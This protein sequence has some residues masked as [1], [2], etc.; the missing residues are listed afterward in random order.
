MKSKMQKR[1]EE[2][3][4]ATNRRTPEDQIKHLD[5]VFGKGQGA[6]KERAKLLKRLSVQPKTVK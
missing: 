4:R 2:Q 6:V 3:L 5:K 1:E